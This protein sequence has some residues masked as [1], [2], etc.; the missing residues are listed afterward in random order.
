MAT[1]FCSEHLDPSSPLEAYGRCSAS[2][3]A[4]I[5]ERAGLSDAPSGYKAEPEKPEAQSGAQQMQADNDMSV[6]PWLVMP[7]NINGV[8]MAMQIHRGSKPEDL[9]RELCHR[10]ELGFNEAAL[11]SC[12]SQVGCIPHPSS[13]YSSVMW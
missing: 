12:I 2:L 11:G 7:L 6:E 4:S 1:A 10:Q 8:E 9:A 5:T 13:R 3:S